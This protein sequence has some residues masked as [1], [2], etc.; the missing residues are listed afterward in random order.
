MAADA[1]VGPDTNTRSE[2]L[3]AILISSALNA[4]G[5]AAGGVIAAQIKGPVIAELVR[6]HQPELSQLSDEVLQ[7]VVVRATEA[8]AGGLSNIVQGLLAD[9]G[10]VVLTDMTFEQFERRV[11]ANMIANGIGGAIMGAAGV[12]AKPRPGP[13]LPGGPPSPGARSRTR[14][15]RRSLSAAPRRRRR[16]TWNAASPAGVTPVMSRIQADPR[17]S[18]M[19]LPFRRTL[20]A[21][22]LMFAAW[23]TTGAT[24]AV[25]GPPV[26][27]FPLPAEFTSPNSITTGPDGALWAPDG[28]LGRVWRTTPKGTIRSYDVGGLPIGIASA[29]GALWVTDGDRHQILRLTTDGKTKPYPV[30]TPGAFPVGI[31]EGPD[32][33]LWFA[34]GR[35]DKIG[36]L[37]LDG[38]ITEYAIPTPGA[39]ATDI[40]VGPDGALWFTEQVG[41]KVGRITTSGKVTE[42]PLPPG[43]LP[44]TIVAGPDGALWFAE[45]N[46]AAINRMSTAG[47]ILDRFPLPD[48]DANPTGLAFG[49]DGLLYVAQHSAD[50]IARMTLAGEVTRSFRV[51][52]GSP[53][54]LANG[55]DGALWFVQNDGLGRLDIGADPAVTAA[56]TTFHARALLPFTRTVAT[57]ED[58]DPN[59]R[60]SDYDVSIAWGDGT[61]SDGVVRRA[62]TGE[63]EVRGRH[64]FLKPRTRQVVVTIDDGVGE[65]PDARVEST[66]I[67]ER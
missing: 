10:A 21:L 50:S 2:N 40:A 8:F 58:A 4:A 5:G 28:S 66:A 7:Q 12:H 59:A 32:G 3:N 16:T 44:G 43:T 41:D 61:R 57:F 14:G 17:R 53:D 9:L 49:L 34:E 35:G 52:S 38:T 20:A 26:T 65:G 62:A 60:P 64:L 39:F 30:P 13:G 1:A 42:F 46:M 22:A 36:R 55:P 25:A 54:H 37:A 23:L 48:A 56:G 63:F 31:V 47:K 33:A 29:H 18:S 51:P 27:E 11:V 45:R 15:A 6:L 19:K 24:A 67:I